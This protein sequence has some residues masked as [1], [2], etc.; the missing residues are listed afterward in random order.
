MEQNVLERIICMAKADSDILNALDWKDGIGTLPGSNIQFRLNEFGLLEII[1][2][3]EAIK[4]LAASAV[5]A[6]PTSFAPAAINT[7]AASST[8]LE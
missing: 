8:V 3:A 7:S 4:T 1:T 5:N 6:N 2:E